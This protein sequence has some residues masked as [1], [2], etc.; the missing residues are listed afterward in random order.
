[1]SRKY[2]DDDNVDALQMFHSSDVL[3]LD[4]KAS[5]VCCERCKNK[6]ECACFAKFSICNLRLFLLLFELF[7]LD[8]PRKTDARKTCESLPRLQGRRAD[9]EEKIDHAFLN[10]S[11]VAGDGFVLFTDR[12]DDINEAVNE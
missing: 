4:D 3:L 7:L 2:A 6:L 12:D 5:L 1:M 8:D 9:A 10:N 11:S